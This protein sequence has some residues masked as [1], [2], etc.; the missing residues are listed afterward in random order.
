M[1]AE[2]GAGINRLIDRI[3]Q[4]FGNSGFLGI[5]SDQLNP[6]LNHRQKIIEIMCDA[7][8]NPPHLL[9]PLPFV[10]QAFVRA[11]LT[12]IAINRGP[13][14]DAMRIGVDRKGIDLRQIAF[15]IFALLRD[16]C[17]DRLP[18]TQLLQ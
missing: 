17:L 5:Q 3:E 6:A 4:I 12:D 14:A 2:F 16:F 13:M 7:T 9:V 8:G 10:G 11:F 1:L 18:A 15:A